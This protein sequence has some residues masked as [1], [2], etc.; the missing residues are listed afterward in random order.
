MTQYEAIDL[1]ISAGANF[2]S[3]FGYW[4]SVSFA[5]IVATFIV[6][7]QFNIGLTLAVSA[8]YLVASAMFALRFVTLASLLVDARSHPAIPEEFLQSLETQ[9][10]FRGVTFIAGFLIT[11]LYVLYTYIKSRGT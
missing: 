6:R 7:D 8:M 10:P 5:V 2:D 4:I 1:I 9:T 3:I 11:E